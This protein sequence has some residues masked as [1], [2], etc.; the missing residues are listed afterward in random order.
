MIM[1][2]LLLASLFPQYDKMIM[3][4]VDTLFVGDISESFFIPLDEHYF[5]MV[6]EWKCEAYVEFPSFVKCRKHDAELGLCDADKLVSLEEAKII[7]SYFFNCG[8]M[9]INLALWRKDNLEKCFYEFILLR[10]AGL[11]C[12]EQDTLILIGYAK[13]L[14]L[15]YKFNVFHGHPNIEKIQ[16]ICMLHFYSESKPWNF[17]DIRNMNMYKKWHEV[18]IQTP[19][20]DKYFNT[21]FLDHLFDALHYKDKEIQIREERIIEEVQAVQSR[22]KEIQ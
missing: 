15:P 9:S 2:R 6:K 21:P 5:G 19:F 1:C 17:F 8:F 18:L 4:D 13:T 10:G 16:E 12:P 3:F 14:E 7:H 11:C 20:K 22:D